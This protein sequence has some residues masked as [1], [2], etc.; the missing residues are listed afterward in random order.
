MPI[1]VF[2]SA[3]A[4]EGEML[5]CRL[6]LA[7]NAIFDIAFTAFEGLTPMLVSSDSMMASDPSHTAFAT[8]VV[9]ALVGDS[10]ETID[11][12]IWVAVIEGFPAA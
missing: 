6:V 8:S 4:D 5:I 9:S 1:S 7:W 10:D 12:S 11:S 3:V 2:D